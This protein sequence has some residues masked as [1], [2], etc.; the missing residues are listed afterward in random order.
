MKKN[1]E[2]INSILRLNELVALNHMKGNTKRKRFY[3]SLM[4]WIISNELKIY[5]HGN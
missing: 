5:G 3:Q 1:K 2:L 4:N